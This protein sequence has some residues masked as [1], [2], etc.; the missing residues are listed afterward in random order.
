MMKIFAC[1]VTTASCPLFRLQPSARQSFR[2][3]KFPDLIANRQM[4][5]FSPHDSL[6]NHPDGGR[7]GF[8]REHDIS[9]ERHDDDMFTEAQI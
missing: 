9:L 4:L 3:H 7:A 8:S 6:I 1:S 2:S 5:T